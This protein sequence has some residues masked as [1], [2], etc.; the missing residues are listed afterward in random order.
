MDA[1]NDRYGREGRRRELAIRMIRLEARSGTVAR[2]SGVSRQSIR[3]LHQAIS[4]THAVRPPK[5]F[6]GPSPREIDVFFRTAAHRAEA[7]AAAVL[8]RLHGAVPDRTASVLTPVPT[9]D[10]GE[11]L[12]D[13]YETYADLVS[14]A[15]LTF[16]HFVLLVDELD[17]GTA[18]ALESCQ[19]CGAALLV[20][21]ATLARR[22]CES[23]RVAR[24]PDPPPEEPPPAAEG[25]GSGPQ[26]ELF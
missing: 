17:A 18:I 5:R 12:C 24:I 16:E 22:R 6:R 9:V 26:G 21:P 10:R 4:R 3:T 1:D 20:E 19:G 7:S 13:A 25:G 11:R 8:C 23:C 15:R 2:W 14:P